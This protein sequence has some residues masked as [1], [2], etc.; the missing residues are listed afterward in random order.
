MSSPPSLVHVDQ[1]QEVGPTHVLPDIQGFCVNSHV[2]VAHEEVFKEGGL[3]S[4]KVSLDSDCEGAA[5][6]VV[7]DDSRVRQWNSLGVRSS[8]SKAKYTDTKYN[9]CFPHFGISAPPLGREY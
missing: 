6:R 2:R 3:A 5:G 7:K 4:A 1:V 9:Y 8:I